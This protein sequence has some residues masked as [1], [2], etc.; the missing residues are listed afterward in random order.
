M[1][2][3]RSIQDEVL[4]VSNSVFIKNFPDQVGSKELWNACKQYGHMVDA[5][6]PDRRSKIGKRFGFVRFIKVFDAERL[7]NNLCTIW[8]GSHRLHASIARFQRPTGQNS[9]R[10]FSHNGEKW[11]DDKG[12]NG[13][14][15]SYAHVLKRVSHP[16]G[17]TTNTPSLVI[18]D[19]GQSGRLFVLSQWKG[20]LWVMLV[21]RSV[22]G[23]D[24]FKVNVGTNSFSLLIETSSDFV[25]DGRVAWVEVEGIPGKTFWIR[26]KEVL[27]WSLEFEQQLDED[28]EPEDDIFGGVDKPNMEN[29]EEEFEDENVVLDT[30]FDDG[31]VKP[32]VVKNSSG[33]QGNKSEDPFDLYP[34]LNKNK[35]EKNKD[36]NCSES[37]KFPPSFTPSV[38]KEVG[39]NMDKQELNCDN[40]NRGA[41]N[42]GDHVNASI[43][44]LYS[45]R[46]GTKSVGS[47]CFKKGDAL[48]T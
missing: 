16:N 11:K 34:L 38:E 19:D 43:D 45:K 41:S 21:F 1:G 5:F 9:S 46:E 29:S 3:R 23:K 7:V 40:L 12:N 27:G 42:Q 39:C 17:D 10:N 6:I 25:V 22:D 15:N 48:R 44:N 18:G 28:S 2:Y 30:V 47:R 37:L 35:G 13:N 14:F 32:S 36:S 26:A 8:I 24:K 20:G 33:N 4:K 31:S